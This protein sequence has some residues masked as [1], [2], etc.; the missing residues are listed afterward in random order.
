MLSPARALLMRPAFNCSETDGKSGSI[1]DWFHANCILYFTL[2]CSP[3]CPCL[4]VI[5]ITPKAARLPYMADEEASFSTEMVAISLPLTIE[6]SSTG[7]PSTIIR[8]E[9]FC[10]F[11]SVPKPRI[12]IDGEAFRAPLLLSTVRP[13][14]APCNA[15][16]TSCTG[17]LPSVFSMSTLA[18]APVRL[19]FFC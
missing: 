19:A 12:D 11:D 8:G 9:E 3:F 7:T 1:V 18:T 15:F 16:E 13:G 6:R 2:T 14:T 17:R 4:V 5:R 10:P